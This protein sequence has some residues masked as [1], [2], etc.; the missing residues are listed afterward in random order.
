MR[1]M[2]TLYTILALFLLGGNGAALASSHSYQE[3]GVTVVHVRD[4]HPY[5]FEGHNGDPSGLLV[6]LW[7]AWSEKTGVP[8]R[9][10]YASWKDSMARVLDGTYD[11]HAGLMQTEERMKQYGFSPPLFTVKNALVAWKSDKRM[12]RTLFED[13]VIGVVTKG[14]TGQIL[15]T[16]FPEARTREYETP[17]KVVEAMAKAEVGAAV[18]NLTTFHFINIKK[19]SPIDY[20]VML[21]LSEETIHAG[22]RKENEALMALVNDGF[23]KLTDSERRNIQERWF[24]VQQ[25]S[26]T[27]PRVLWISGGLILVV[28]VLLIAQ[29]V[30]RRISKTS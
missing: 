13:E 7:L 10:A 17:E 30:Y 26:T 23:S 25:E 16:Q 14:H 9:F 3:T 6:E 29:L 4:A 2:V 20:D 5:F 19:G 1:S 15:S 11:I 22:V 24:V 28:F 12:L 18:M 8:V 27:L 21:T